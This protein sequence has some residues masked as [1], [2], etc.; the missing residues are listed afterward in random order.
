MRNFLAMF[1]LLSMMGLTVMVAQHTTGPEKLVFTAKNG[2]VN[3]DHKAHSTREKDDC[4]VCHPALWPQDA[5][6]PLNYKAAMHKTAESK[7]TAC[8]ACHV[9]GGKAFASAGSCAKCHTK[10]G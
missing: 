7:K 10:K 8:G 9:P 5:K 1:L 3:Y 6:A 2:N 4:K